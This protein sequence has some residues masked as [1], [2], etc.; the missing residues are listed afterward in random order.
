[1]HA[2]INI[3]CGKDSLIVD[4]LFKRALAV[5]TQIVI[6]LPREDKDELYDYFK[7]HP[8]T[9]KLFSRIHSILINFKINFDTNCIS[10]CKAKKTFMAVDIFKEILSFIKELCESHHENFQ[11]MIY[12]QECYQKSYDIIGIIIQCITSLS[13]LAM[14]CYH[15]PNKTKL[16]NVRSEENL[17]LIH[18]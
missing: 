18:I 9:E 6:G 3:L 1:M 10:K 2:L 14:L 17:S 12:K 7:T 16:I 11:K 8:N 4:K 13:K 5:T 15:E